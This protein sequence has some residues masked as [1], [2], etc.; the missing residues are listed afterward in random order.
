MGHETFLKVFN[1]PQ[2]VYYV[3]LS[4]F[5]LVIS[6]KKLWGSDH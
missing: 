2:K 3:L 1:E 4:E 6:F 5:Y